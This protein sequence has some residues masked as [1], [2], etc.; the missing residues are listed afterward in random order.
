MS[1]GLL[2]R[3]D[4]VSMNGSFV[5]SGLPKA[6]SLDWMREGSGGGGI[7]DSWLPW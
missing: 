6:E 4:C 2:R 5:G 7:D 1:E 3:I